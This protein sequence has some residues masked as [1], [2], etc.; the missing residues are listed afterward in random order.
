MS[1]SIARTTDKTGSSVHHEEWCKVQH[2]EVMTGDVIHHSPDSELNY[3]QFTGSMSL[4]GYAYSD[5]QMTSADS[6]RVTLSMEH[7][8][9]QDASIMVDLTPLE[10]LCLASEL[11]AHAGALMP[12]GSL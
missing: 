3:Q 4:T 8:D 11:I 1:K 12:G 2:C 9:F 5:G 7:R 6:A 10:A